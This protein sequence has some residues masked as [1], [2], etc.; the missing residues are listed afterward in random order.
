[1]GIRYIGINTTSRWD[2][3][4]NRKGQAFTTDT[5]CDAAIFRAR[6][7]YENRVNRERAV[8]ESTLDKMN[9]EG[10]DL[11]DPD[12][13]WLRKFLTNYLPELIEKIAKFYLAFSVL[14]MFNIFHTAYT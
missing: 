5:T 10:L 12:A 1:M 3:Y 9:L 2:M 7:E 4:C 8:N 13:G 14:L 6:A 11:N